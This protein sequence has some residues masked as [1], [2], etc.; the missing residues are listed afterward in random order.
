MIVRDATPEDW[1]AIWAFVAEIVRAGD[2]FTYD[3]AMSEQD[4]RAM[5]LMDPPDRTVVAEQDG[6]V[7]GSANYHRNRSGPGA[8]VASA[9]FMV[10]PAHWGKGVGRA[11]CEE[12]L[13][14]AKRRGYR[15]MQFNAV[16]ESNT[17]AIALYESL[18]F[19]TVGTVPE[20]FEHPTLGYV[21]LCVMWRRL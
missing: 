6:T 9:N 14:W 20:A 1:P 8:H 13:D 19:E 21:T 2:T 7:L 10:D 16:A 11:L 5:W 17:R 12:G 4:A 3:P 15:A 18:G